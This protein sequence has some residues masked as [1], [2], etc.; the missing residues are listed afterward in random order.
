MSIQKYN[1]YN[2]YYDSTR[3]KYRPQSDDESFYDPLKRNRNKIYSQIIEG[4]KNG[5][6]TKQYHHYYVQL[7]IENLQYS[8]HAKKRIHDK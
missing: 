7:F 2:R 8:G 1:I 4:R 3:K 5:K 6:A